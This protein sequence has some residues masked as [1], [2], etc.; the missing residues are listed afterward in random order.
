MARGNA[1]SAAVSQALETNEQSAGALADLRFSALLPARDWADLPAAV[2]KR[3]SKRLAPG[4]SV[5]YGGQVTETRLSPLGWLLAQA[6]RLIGAP[7][8]LAA[9]SRAAAWVSVTEDPSVGGQV[10]S[11]IY[12]R[13]GRFPQ[14]IHSFKRFSGPTGLEE[15][16][17]RGVGMTLT[18][19][20]EA[21]ALVFRSAGFFLELGRLRLALPRFLMPG[22]FEIVHR[23]E[24]EGRFSFTLSLRHRL[25]GEM[26]YQKALFRDL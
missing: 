12:H 5:I 1:A 2:R 13:P 19:R 11:R 4:G 18:L 6:A 22:A 23:E 20:V 15:Y 16:V 17:G 25:F 8:P 10:W 9:G 14:V 21:R 3:F 24:A 7:L 26:I